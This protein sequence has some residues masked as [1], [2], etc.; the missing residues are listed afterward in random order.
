MELNNDKINDAKENLKLIILLLNK[1]MIQNCNS[2]NKI[3]LKIIVYIY[4]NRNSKI[5]ISGQT[6]QR[7]KNSFHTFP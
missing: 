6:K 4:E 1:V 2:C 5:I 3:I 7:K